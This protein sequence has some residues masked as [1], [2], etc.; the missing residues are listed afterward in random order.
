M[1]PLYNCTIDK[2]E[3][4]FFIPS[5]KSIHYYHVVLFIELN[6]EVQTIPKSPGLELHPFLDVLASLLSQQ[7]IKFL[8]STV[9]TVSNVSSVSLH[10]LYKFFC[11]PGPLNRTGTSGDPRSMKLVGTIWETKKMEY[12]SLIVK[13]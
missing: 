13:T 4:I 3:L 12:D 9:S 6:I 2:L 5:N 10:N 7:S 1:C 11:T 8:V